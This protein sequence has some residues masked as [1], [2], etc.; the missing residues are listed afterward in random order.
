MSMPD[1]WEYPWYAAW[2]L[3]FHCLPLALIDAEFAKAAGAADPRVV[4]APERPAAGLRV[5]LRRRQSAGARL[6]GVAGVPDRPQAAPR[7]SRAT[8][9]ATRRPGFPRARLPQA[10]AQL[11]LVGEPQGRTG[12]QHLPGR[13]PRARQHRLLRPQQALADR[14]LHQP[15]RRHQL[16]G[17]VLPQPAAHRARAGASTTTS[18]RTSPPSSSSTSCHRRRRSTALATNHPPLGRG[19][20]V[21]LRPPAACPTDATSPLR[22]HSMVGL[23]PLFAVQPGCPTLLAQLPEFSARMEWYLEHRPDLAALISNWHVP[24]TRRIAF[25]CRCC[26]ATAPRPCCAACSTRA[27]SCRPTA[28]A[29]CRK[30]HAANPSA[31]DVGG[32]EL[33]SRLLAGRVAQ[34][35]VRRQLELARA[36]LDAGQLPDHRVAAEVPPLLRR[37]FQGRVPDRLGQ[38][39]DPQGGGR[40]TEPAPDA[41][42]SSRAKTASGR[43]QDANAKL[44]DRPALSRLICCSHEYF[45]GDDGRG[46]GAA[47]QTGWT[48]RP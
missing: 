7:L 27:S 21:L 24:G 30:S 41:A 40:R 1:K 43:C 45:H 26:A 3:A 9:P 48:R 8:R 19:G 25:C 28:C 31:F 6:G 36:D 11:H 12:P 16:D 42:C 38:V 23:I 33:R 10:A 35:A 47:H 22:V 34:R 32:A 46:V 20:P 13:L 2:D 5:G 17:D 4:H 39:P 44:A 29:R 15:G 37:R 14:R 18:T